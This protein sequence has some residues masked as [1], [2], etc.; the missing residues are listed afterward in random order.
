MMSSMSPAPGFRF[1]QT[2]DGRDLQ[3]FDR[4]HGGDKLV[5]RDDF[6]QDRS[7]HDLKKAQRA[8]D[9]ADEDA[10]FAIE[11][12]YAAIEEAEYA[13]LDA[14]LAHVQVDELAGANAGS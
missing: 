8:A 9:S 13:V 1:G 4:S 12:V 11:Y 3:S 6:D 10:E 2:T 7:E 5:I 14:E